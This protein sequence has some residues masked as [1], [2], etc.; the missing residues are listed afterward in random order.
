MLQLEGIEVN[1]NKYTYITVSDK[2]INLITNKYNY[3]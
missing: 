3:K 1:I 2:Y